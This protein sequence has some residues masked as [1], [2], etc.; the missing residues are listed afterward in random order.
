MSFS[1]QRLWFLFVAMGFLF[2]VVI[3]VIYFQ[4][5]GFRSVAN[6]CTVVMTPVTPHSLPYAVAVNI[7]DD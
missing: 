4:P 7:P 5:P 2:Y 1:L 3:V 6:R